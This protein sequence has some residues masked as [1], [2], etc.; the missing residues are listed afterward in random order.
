MNKMEVWSSVELER[1]RYERELRQGQPETWSCD[2]R[3]RDVWC[4]GRWLQE[5]YDHLPGDR[6]RELLSLFNRIIRPVDDVFYAAQL[7]VEA[8]DLGG[9]TNNVSKDFWTARRPRR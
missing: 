9:D 7:V 2:Q 4:I 5:R 6:K 3:T 8:G 1:P